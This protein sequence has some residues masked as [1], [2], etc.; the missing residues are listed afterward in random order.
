MLKKSTLYKRKKSKTNIILPERS[1]AKKLSSFEGL[2]KEIGLIKIGFK[3]I[4]V[5]RKRGGKNVSVDL[6]ILDQLSK[7]ENLKKATFIH[8][9]ILGKIKSPKSANISAMDFSCFVN[10]C[11]KYG[12]SNFEVSI[13]G[14]DLIEMGRIHIMFSSKFVEELNKKNQK[15]IN[16]WLSSIA[17]RHQM[18]FSKTSIISELRNI[19]SIIKY[20]SLNGYKLEEIKGTPFISK[21]K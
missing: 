2:D 9:H 17:F 13:L 12:I 7:T 3:I 14:K 6:K 1:F 5:S 10:Y 19:G 8:T 15:E 18:N 4:N 21:I 16:A 11:K 20:V